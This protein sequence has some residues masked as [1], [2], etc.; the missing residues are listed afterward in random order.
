MAPAAFVGPVVYNDKDKFKKV[1]FAEIDKEAADPARKPAFTRA[2][3]TVIGMS[4]YY[5]VAARLPP[6][7]G[8]R[9]SSTRTRSTAASTRPASYAQAPSRRARPAEPRA[10]LYVGP[11]DQDVLAKLAPGRPRAWRARPG[12]AGRHRARA[13]DLAGA[14]PARSCRRRSARLPCRGRCRASSCRTA[15]GSFDVVGRKPGGDEVVLDHAD[16]AV[17]G[18]ACVN[19]DLRDGSAASLS[20]SAKSTFLNLSCVVVDDR[21]DERRRRHRARARR[22]CLVSRIN[23]KYASGVIGAR[24]GVGDVERDVDQVAAAMER[25][26]LHDI[27]AVGGGRL[28]LQS[29]VVGAGGKRRAVRAA[30]RRRVRWF[31]RPSPIEPRL[32]DERALGIALQREVGLRSCHSASRCL[33]SATARDRRRLAVSMSA[34]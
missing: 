22:R 34:V 28:Q 6:D 19:A 26:H 25:Q 1:D 9:A 13:C 3:T 18:V 15:R 29:S 4:E 16:P 14:R 21:T 30:P 27:V 12:P 17:V 7:S 2:A 33:S 32:G 31:G 8:W 5:F 11:Q 20:I 24:A 10:R 23:W